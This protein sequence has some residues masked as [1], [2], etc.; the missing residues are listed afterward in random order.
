MNEPTKP[1]G[2]H[3][4]CACTDCIRYEH[5]AFGGPLV[6]TDAQLA[7]RERALRLAVLAEELSEN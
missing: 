3:R 6:L 5:L 7:E 4:L 2:H 1:R